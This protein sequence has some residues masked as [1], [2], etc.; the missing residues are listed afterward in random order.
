MNPLNFLIGLIILGA[1]I[2]CEKTLPKEPPP[3]TII[4]YYRLQINDNDGKFIHS[5]IVTGKEVQSFNGNPV[6]DDGHHECEEHPEHCPIVPI[7]LEYFNISIGEKVILSWKMAA[8][9]N[10]KD[11]EIQSSKDG[12]TFKTIAIVFPNYL[13]EYLIKL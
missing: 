1:F 10:V 5:Q 2:S 4:T 12:I 13:G 3:T 9:D 11:F 7:I 8:Q 6:S